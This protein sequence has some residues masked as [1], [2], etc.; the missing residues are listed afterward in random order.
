LPPSITTSGFSGQTGS[1]V[2]DEVVCGL[3]PP[4]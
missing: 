1:Q 2:L 3:S 4:A